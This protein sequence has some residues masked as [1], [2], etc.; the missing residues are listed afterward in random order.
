[1]T[2][3]LSFGILA[4]GN[5]V[6]AER[7][8][9]PLRLENLPERLLA[10]FTCFW[11]FWTVVV[12]AA[13]A[14]GCIALP[15]IFSFQLAG[16]AVVWAATWKSEPQFG[17]V[18][19]FRPFQTSRSETKARRRSVAGV[20]Q[21]TPRVA[22]VI[23][24]TLSAATILWLAWIGWRM[25]TLPVSDYD[26]TSI[27]GVQLAL[28]MQS[29]SIALWPWGHPA[30]STRPLN[31]PIMML[32]F[33]LPFQSLSAGQ[34]F[35]I[36]C[37][38]A[39]LLGLYRLT[40]LAGASS[41]ASIALAFVPFACHS[42][43]TQFDLSLLY[44]DL[45]AFYC[46][47]AFLWG[48]RALFVEC[49]RRRFLYQTLLAATTGMLVGMRPRV[50]LFLF[51][52]HLVIAVVVA[53][54]M[55]TRSDKLQHL[56]GWFA[57]PLLVLVGVGLLGGL[58]RNGRSLESQSVE[59]AA[60]SNPADADAD[61]GAAS[62]DAGVSTAPPLAVSVD[63]KMLVP[64]NSDDVLIRCLKRY[65]YFITGPMTDARFSYFFS[66]HLGFPGSI[67]ALAAPVML[68]WLPWKMR[69]ASDESIRYVLAGLVC[70][71]VTGGLFAYY[72][73][74]EN[75]DGRYY[76][77]CLYLGTPALAYL[78]RGAA[79]KQAAGAALIC[80]AAV[81][82]MAG[83]PSGSF[84]APSDWVRRYRTL[85]ADD[86]TFG[87]FHAYVG[88][89]FEDLTAYRLVE[90]KIPESAVIARH[91]GKTYDLHL[92]GD[93]LEREVHYVQDPSALE[94]LEQQGPVNF[95]MIHH[96]FD[97]MSLWYSEA[98]RTDN[99]LP[100]R[101]LRYCLK[102]PEKYRLIYPDPR[103]AE[104]VERREVIFKV[105]D[106]QIASRRESPTLR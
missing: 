41:S 45:I 47:A 17:V 68:C 46:L 84:L 31:A 92:F 30:V 52:L 25:L 29:K 49:S 102:H 74:W 62:L 22:T 59:S 50:A 51:A 1:M 65:W 10:G 9:R 69:T 42:Y 80:A 40:R 90:S 104:K 103:N 86:Q 13:G 21:A 26:S 71:A 20:G 57:Y 70:A 28:M 12:Y 77:V 87:S 14:C 43:V 27:Y 6:A 63:G 19:A 33:S 61:V 72:Q 18:A 98:R 99:V 44:D 56:R 91:S 58:H 8:T 78:T 36:A 39:Q 37:V 82:T 95:V 94:R 88:K 96:P 105:I 76:L 67:L 93:D 79:W 106:P 97:P 15:T 3:W 16:L 4:L 32:F 2:G 35:H 89:G 23:L 11:A 24:A 60:N 7:L 73:Y 54:R 81:M 5:G 55:W 85:P 75:P 34:F 101:L 66:T 53:V 38:P 48:S 83:Q 64:I 100:K